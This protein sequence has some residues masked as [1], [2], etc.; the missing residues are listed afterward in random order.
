MAYNKGA[1]LFQLGRHRE[2]ELCYLRCLQDKAISAERRAKALYDLGVACLQRGADTKDVEAL[3]R[4]VEAFDLCHQEAAD[5]KLKDDAGY[6]QD[7]APG[8]ITVTP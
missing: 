3:Q 2:A 1:A 7:G 8:A 5:K 6:N 4:A